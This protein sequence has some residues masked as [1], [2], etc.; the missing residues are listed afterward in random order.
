MKNCSSNTILSAVIYGSMLN[1]DSSDKI[2]WVISSGQ[3]SYS[4]T[5]WAVSKIM[6]NNHICPDNRVT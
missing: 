3:Y 5:V 6:F 2:N 4:V 1:S